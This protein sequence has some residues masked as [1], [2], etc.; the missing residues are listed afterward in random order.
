[1]KRTV[2]LLFCLGLIAFFIPCKKGYAAS[3]ASAVTF[4]VVEEN[5]FLYTTTNS[6]RKIAG[7]LTVGEIY[8]GTIQ[9]TNW[10]GVTVGKQTFFID[11]THT[12]PVTL[13]QKEFVHKSGYKVRI[14]KEAVL[15]KRPVSISPTSAQ[16]YE[17]FELEVVKRSGGWYEVIAFGEVH[18]LPVHYTKE[19]FTPE[20]DLFFAKINRRFSNSVQ[21]LIVVKS[22][23]EQTISAKIS[24]YEIMAG[25]WRRSLYSMDAVV[26]KNGLTSNKKE[27]DGKTPMGVF[28]LGTAFGSEEKPKQVTWPYRKTS[29]YDYWIDDS[30]SKDYNK[31]ITFR[32][33]PSTKWKSYEKMLQPLYKYGVVI[34]HN[35][36]PIKSGKGSAIFLHIWKG[37]KNPTA[38]CIAI[39]EKNILYVLNWLRAEKNPRLFIGTLDSFQRY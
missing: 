18:Y 8:T 28:P 15:K 12:K 26:G 5:T 34:N 20:E 19:V 17:G 22:A 1:L 25:G 13:N 4:Q 24:F 32:G 30:L 3:E 2:G 10:Y 39:E 9:S 29:T 14:I 21:Q 6:Q 7:K 35:M 23:K 37:S 38:G 33:N 36:N 11:K 31:W 27:G 16:L